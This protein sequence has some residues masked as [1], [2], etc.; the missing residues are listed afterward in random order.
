MH[1]RSRLQ[2]AGSGDLETKEAVTTPASHS[3]TGQNQNGNP[4]V[5]TPSPGLA[6]TP[7]TASQKPRGGGAETPKGKN[8]KHKRGWPFHSHPASSRPRFPRPHRGRLG[9]GHG[10]R[11]PAS[12]GGR[13]G[14]AARIPQACS[15]RANIDPGLFPLAV[16]GC[17]CS[18]GSCAGC[19]RRRQVEATSPA[20]VGA[21]RTPPAAQGLVPAP[22]TPTPRSTLLVCCSNTRTAQTQL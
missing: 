3:R 20:G 18:G 14:H 2:F 5:L 4:G 1:W 11:G 13:R 22:P 17:V 15:A 16:Q 12:P 21:R 6:G 9:Q 8:G 19:G 7:C 10:T